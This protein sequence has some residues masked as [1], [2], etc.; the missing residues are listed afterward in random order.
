M[1]ETWFV[2]WVWMAVPWNFGPVPMTAGWYSSLVF[3][4]PNAEVECHL[5]SVN[6]SSTEVLVQCLPASI[7][8]IPISKV[9]RKNA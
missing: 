8:P 9:D 5:A 3:S 4:P 7:E 6:S 2:L 1:I